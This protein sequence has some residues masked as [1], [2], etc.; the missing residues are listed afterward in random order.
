MQNLNSYSQVMHKE[1]FIR[2]MSELSAKFINIPPAQVDAHINQTLEELLQYFDVDR[3]V[4]LRPSPDQPAYQITNAASTLR[5]PLKVPNAEW[6]KIDLLHR[7]PWSS[8]RLARQEVVS[9][10]SLDR[11]PPEAAVDR[12]THLQGGNKSILNVPIFVKGEI[13]AI[14]VLTAVKRERSWPEEYFNHL[15]LIGEV[16]VNSL[17]H[18]TAQ[19]ELQ[20]SYEE[21]KKLKD[22]LQAESEYLNVEVKLAHRYGEIIG[23][24]QAMK[25]VLQRL[26]QVAVSDATV[27]IQGE[28]GTGK[29]LIARAIHTISNRRNRTMVKIDCASLPPSLIEGELFGREKGAY[30]GALSKQLG[31]F[32]IADGSTLFF[33]EIGELPLELQGK[34]L[35]VLQDREFERLGSNKTVKVDVRVVAATNRNLADEMQKGRFR[36]DLFFR[37]NVF[38]VML[39]PLRERA[40]DI[41]LL[42]NVFVDE[43]SKKMGKRIERVPSKIMDALQGYKWPGNIRELRNVI[44]NAVVITTGRALNVNLPKEASHTTNRIKT[45]KEIEYQHIMQVLETTDWSIKGPC[46][47]AKLLGLKPSTLYNLMTRLDIPTRRHKKVL[48]RT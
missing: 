5:G 37:L 35:R 40:E 3:C 34:L 33:D 30:T 12:Q 24:S 1:Y 19:E 41:P 21:V 28:T 29:E 46:G 14:L 27:M 7:Y 4:L 32:E 15:R 44:E 18:K 10:E 31:R 25:K 8:E 45:L 43:F 23:Q 17:L 26:E 13:N 20:K 47:A 36:E 11:L 6:K 48:I 16:F 38:P 22:L 2:L 39:P 42:V 9:I